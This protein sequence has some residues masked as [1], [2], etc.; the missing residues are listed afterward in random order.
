MKEEFL[1]AGMGPIL[2]GGLLVA[3]GAAV[4]IGLISRKGRRDTPEPSGTTELRFDS[5]D[6]GGPEYSVSIEDNEII[7]AEIHRK[8]HKADHEE[9]GGAGY[10]V[11]VKI[12]GLKP[13]RTTLTV[14]SRSPIC[15]NTDILYTA[16]VSDSLEVTLTKESEI[17][18]TVERVSVQPMALIIHTEKK[19]LCVSKNYC[20]AFEAL[21]ENL[22]NDVP[23]LEF[24]KPEGEAI[25]AKLP[26][27][28]SGAEKEI[29]LSPGDVALLED[30]MIAIVREEFTTKASLIGSLIGTDI[31]EA[32]EI[33]AAGD[34][35]AVLYVEWSE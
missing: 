18:R 7:S 21:V 10:E 15:E 1:R 25:K 31:A 3:A 16:E 23:E 8:Y 29:T 6:G 35:H 19:D 20:P 2:L 22:R 12:K 34:V 11:I 24:S 5:F 13:G 9:L 28:I 32:D 27:S 17:D 4:C 33:F 30:D 26:F 14:S